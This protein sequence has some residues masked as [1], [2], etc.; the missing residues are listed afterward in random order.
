MQPITVSKSELKPKLLH[1]LRLVEEKGQPINI[2]HH[3]KVVAQLTPARQQSDEEILKS[4][5]GRIIIHGDIMEPV[6][7]EDWEALK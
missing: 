2:T 5:G 3:S 1:Y 4:L 6:G 7:V